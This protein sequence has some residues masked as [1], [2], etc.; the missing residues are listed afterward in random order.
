MV[1]H[2]S[3]TLLQSQRQLVVSEWRGLQGGLVYRAV[4]R[5]G[6]SEG[7]HAQHGAGTARATVPGG[8]TGEGELGGGSLGQGYS[9]PLIPLHGHVTGQHVCPHIHNGPG[10]TSKIQDLR[11]AMIGWVITKK[12]P[13]NGC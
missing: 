4:V 8:A 5:S 1:S 11:I 2:D 9:R 13:E 7:A 3:K 6:Q 12:L 10:L